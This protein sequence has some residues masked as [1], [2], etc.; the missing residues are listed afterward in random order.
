M[1]PAGPYF[2]DMPPNGRLDKTDALFVD[3]LHTDGNYKLAIK[4]GIGTPIGH[5]DFYPNGGARQPGCITFL[6]KKNKTEAQVDM[7]EVEE[8]GKP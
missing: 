8:Y 1:D 2:W 5:V 7:P 4:C 3:N 6:Q